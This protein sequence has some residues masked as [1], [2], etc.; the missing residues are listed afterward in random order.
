[1]SKQSN[2]TIKGQPFHSGDAPDFKVNLR[3]SN[4]ELGLVSLTDIDPKVYQVFQKQ[5][6]EY[7]REHKLP[8]QMDIGDFKLSDD[9]K[10]VIGNLLLTNPIL[11]RWALVA[12]TFD[13]RDH[14]SSLD[15]DMN[16]MSKLPKMVIH[17]GKP[18][19]KFVEKILA[20]LWGI[21]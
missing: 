2:E 6:M 7:Q 8:M 20:D 13:H 4:S 17:T 19:D 16:P 15:H 21:K 18:V 14:P 5:V 10:E 12:V 3:T 11:N 1:M 9:K